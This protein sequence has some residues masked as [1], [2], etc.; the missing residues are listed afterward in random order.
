MVLRSWAYTGSHEGG[1]RL[2]GIV[3]KF[4]GTIIDNYIDERC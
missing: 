2:A 3:E 1:K 4:T